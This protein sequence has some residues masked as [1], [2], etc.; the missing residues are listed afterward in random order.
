MRSKTWIRFI[1]GTF[2]LASLVGRG[3]QS[4]GAA[5]SDYIEGVVTSS[6]G[7]EAGVW[8]IAETPDLPTKYAKV[9]VTDDRGRYVLPQL[10]NANYK[11]WVRG[12]GLVDST[13]V[14]G[15]P[16]QKID[17]KAVVA[18]DG[19]AAA[20]VYPANYWLSLLKVPPGQLSADEAAGG[21]KACLICHQIGD[22]ATRELPPATKKLGTFK[23]NLDAWD[24][25]TKSGPSGAAMSGAYMALGD[26]RVM[27]AD[28]TDR[29]AA[30]DYPKEAPPRPKGVER[31]IVLTLWD[32]GTPTSYM[33]DEA[34]SDLR[35]PTVNPNGPVYGAL[36][37]GNTIAVLDPVKNTASEI[38]VPSNGV[39]I[40]SMFMPSPYWG[41][42]NIWLSASQP[43]SAVVDEKGRAWVAARIRGGSVPADGGKQPDFCK[44]GSGN[45]FAEYY[46][47]DRG[48][49][50]VAV[51]DPA[52]KKVSEIDTCFTT[53]HNE[54]AN[55]G[56]LFFGMTGAVGWVNSKKWDE[57]H[58]DEQSQGWI[59]GVLDTNGD[60]KITKPWTE[61]NEPIDPAKDHRI[62]FGCYSISISPVDGSVWCSGIGANQH[63]L[64]RLERGPNPPETSKAEIYEPPPGKEPPLFSV[65]GVS[66]DT[67]GVAWQN[68]RGSDYI[69]SFDRRKCKVLMGPAATG[70]QCPEGWTIYDTPGPHFQ[71]GTNVKSSVN[72]LIFVDR[73]GILGLGN[74]VPM[75]GAVNSDAVYAIL[76]KT[77]EFVTIRL[78][79]PMGYY[80]RSMQGRVDDPKAGWK[81]RGFW[82]SYNTYTPWH[83]EGG[84]GAKDKVVKIQMRPDP[85][86]R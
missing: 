7:P 31:N 42:E 8:V 32:W 14:Q 60:G 2:L 84:M 56:S 61:P 17:L 72:Y 20:Q 18:P 52:T 5:A 63:S 75:T 64:V 24:R 33:H 53:D 74:D 6:N 35:D 79:Y 15:K 51:Y 58:S 40:G 77:G 62:N 55:D 1:L 49:K 19:K 48:N 44:A 57:A 10:P 45:R 23:N 70:Q 37:S 26:Q 27:F 66:V 30:G 81:G 36:S 85:L 54:F 16:G 28:W 21:V 86:A 73:H 78:P 46:P 13:P 43:R 50:Q 41:D 82:T 65:G 83:M 67:N 22:K 4:R 59:P 3:S 38:L 11:V 76:P 34:A 47:L 71:G 68:W 12:Y 80:P 9:V 39:P 69:T 29:V 25:R